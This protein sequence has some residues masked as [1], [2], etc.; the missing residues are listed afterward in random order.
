MPKV[1]VKTELSTKTAEI[2]MKALDVNNTNLQAGFEELFA[3]LPNWALERFR[4]LLAGIP[5]K[6]PKNIKK[7]GR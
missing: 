2:L 6:E 7:G 1:S 3:D 4:G 5:P